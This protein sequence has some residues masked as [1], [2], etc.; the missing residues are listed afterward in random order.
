LSAEQ[1]GSHMPILIAGAGIGGLASALLLGRDGHPVTVLEKR[2]RIEEVGAGIQLSPNASQILV[3]MGLGQALAR[4]AGEPERLMVRRGIGGARLVTMPLGSVMRERFGAPYFVVHRADLQ[5]LLLDAVRSLANVRLLFGR[6]VT[7]VDQEGD[8]A[9]VS[10]TEANGPE[11]YRGGLLI[12]ADGLWSRV[13]SAIG[14]QS[15]PDFT[16]YVAWRG[17]VDAEK[18][19]PPFRRQETGLWLGPGAHVVHYPLRAGKV[20]NVVAVVSDRNAEPGWSRPGASDHLRRRF[21]AWSPELKVLFDAVPEWQVWSLFDRA[22][23]SSWC[24]GR[25]ALLGDA[26]HPILP[27]L[28]QG[29]AFAIEDAAVLAHQ[30]R[31]C[32]GDV[33]KALRT[34]AEKRRPRAAA[35]QAAARRNGGIYHMHDP[36]AVARDLVMK[37]MGGEGLLNRYRWLYDWRPDR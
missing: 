1:A 21:G 11:T 35:I 15:E 29:G 3:G 32:G 16:G 26:A 18:A 31:T 9:V 4:A 30:L 5:T 24:K 10:V 8:E 19:P 14:D 6:S 2:T 17:V 25:T 12:G 28:A 7:S 36:F 27:F 23:R 22:P 20:V 13:A 37:Q 34:Y 33:P